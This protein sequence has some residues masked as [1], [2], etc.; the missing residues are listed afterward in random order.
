M[1]LLLCFDGTT[2]A[3]SI[4]FHGS[5]LLLFANTT[6]GFLLP[7]HT[8]TCNLHIFG[9]E[10]FSGLGSKTYLEVV[11][12]LNSVVVTSVPLVL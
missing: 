8:I 4:N 9:P 2:T 6:S 3:G 12:V 5:L 10:L 11:E 1:R 7:C